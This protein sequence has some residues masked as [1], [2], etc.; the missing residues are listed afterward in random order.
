MPHHA[1]TAAHQAARG[2]VLTSAPSGC[3]SARTSCSSKCGSCSPMSNFI[4][5]HRVCCPTC[6]EAHK[7]LATVHAVPADD[8][9]SSTAPV[10]SKGYGNGQLVA[11]SRPPT[12]VSRGKTA[13]LCDAAEQQ[14]S[15]YAHSSIMLPGPSLEVVASRIKGEP[16]AHDGNLPHSNTHHKAPRQ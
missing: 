11:C 3:V 12:T 5:Q 13:A 7:L 16:L 9:D 14:Q 2:M 15:R 4:L 8:I 1:G 6:P 10:H